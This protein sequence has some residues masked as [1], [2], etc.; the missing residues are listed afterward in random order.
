MYAEY[1]QPQLTFLTLQ[2]WPTWSIRTISL[3]KSMTMG[4]KNKNSVLLSHPLYGT[5]RS[6]QSYNNLQPEDLLAD[7]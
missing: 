1:T 6:G 5:N 4:Y 3:K 7:S 2:P